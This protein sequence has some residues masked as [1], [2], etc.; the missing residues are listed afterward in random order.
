MDTARQNISRMPSGFVVRAA[1]F[2]CYVTWCAV[3]LWAVGDAVRHNDQATYIN[4]GLQ[5]A[6]GEMLPWHTFPGAGWGRADELFNYDKEFGSYWLI[7]AVLWISG[8]QSVVLVTNY[9]QAIAFCLSLGALVYYRLWRLPISLVLPFALCPVLLLSVPFMGTGMISLTFLLL[10]FAIIRRG[11]PLRQGLACFLIAVAAACRGDVVLAVPALIMC[12]ISRRNFRGLVTSPIV[13]ITSL[14][15][16]L[17]P[18]IGLLL[19][20]SPSQTFLSLAPSKVVIAFIIFG[21]GVTV[22]ALLA[23][24]SLFFLAAGTHKSRWRLFY[25]LRALSPLIPFGFYVPH[26][27]S[28]Q[29]FFLTLACYLFTISDRRALLAFSWLIEPRPLRRKLIWVAVLLLLVILP[30]FV[31]LKAPSLAKL[32]PTINFPQDFPT[33]HGHYPMGAYAFYLVHSRTHGYILDHNQKIF[34][35]AK[36]ILYQTC[37]GK[38]P[39]LRTSMYNY[40]ELAVRLDG[41]SPEIVNIPKEVNCRTYADARSLIRNEVA[42]S[43]DLLHRASLVASYYGQAILELG[44]SATDLGIL[45]DALQDRLSGREFEFYVEAVDSPFEL[46]NSA[47]GRVLYALSRGECAITPDRFGNAD[48]RDLDGV[49]IYLWTVPD[50]YGSGVVSMTCNSKGR[51]GQVTL[52]L[53]TW[54]GR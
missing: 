16:I 50:D 19:T 48:V 43:E 33:A 49:R 10:G 44:G 39:V 13:W 15:S 38:V 47:N 7:A 34:L 9:A 4:G 54:M 53:P 17:P 5:I 46:K 52:V 12:E 6:Q 41:L 37:N 27:T 35:A 2:L 29:Q 8:F 30:W 51:A 1:V 18:V 42:G 25:T 45:L 40:L 31:G 28:P 26:L 21:L 11:N 36:N 32:R 24:S 20:P 14:C 23:W 22:L 3:V